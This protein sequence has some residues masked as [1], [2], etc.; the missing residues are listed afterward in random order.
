M[1]FQICA[2][3]KCIPKLERSIFFFFVVVVCI[4]A[5]FS[6]SA[7]DGIETMKNVAAKEKKILIIIKNGSLQFPFY[8]LYNPFHGTETFLANETYLA[9]A[10]FTM[11]M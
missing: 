1:K 4:V 2:A 11:F 6:K 10:H 8:L 5:F 7:L 3:Q 9:F